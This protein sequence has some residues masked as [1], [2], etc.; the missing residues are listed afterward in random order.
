MMAH[1]LLRRILVAG[2][3]AALAGG[4]AF[5]QDKPAAAPVKKPAAAAHPAAKEP[6]EN[7]MGHVHY[8][9]YRNG[10]RG[11]KFGSPS[12][13]IP[14]LSLT[15]EQGAMKIYQKSGETLNIGD[16]QLDKI[17]YHFVDDKFMGVSLFPKDSDDGKELLEI[18]EIAFGDGA[19]ARPHAD[20][21]AHHEHADEFFWKGKI[22]NA[23]LS[24]TEAHIA[25]A[26]IGNNALQDAY[27]K[28]QK[29][30]AEAA[31]ATLF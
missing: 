7:E 13:A 14:G 16:C 24:Y 6:A 8:L 21:S 19:T 29:K 30:A 15:R 10:F 22:A 1:L 20:A 18:F 31:A 4:L 25:E 26:W 2:S 5:A 9:D 23:R 27:G 28:V 17:L 12:S 3:T 11:V